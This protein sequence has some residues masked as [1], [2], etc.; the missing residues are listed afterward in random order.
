MSKADRWFLMGG[1]VNGE[2]LPSGCRTSIG[3]VKME[4]TEVAAVQG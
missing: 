1:E 3:A 2:Y 4:Q